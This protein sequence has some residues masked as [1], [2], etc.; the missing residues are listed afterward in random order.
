M[1]IG[2]KSF[3][4]IRQKSGERSEPYQENNEVELSE[5]TGADSYD[6]EE[7]CEQ[8]EIAGLLSS[9]NTAQAVGSTLQ[10]ALTE[11]QRDLP[12]TRGISPQRRL[13]RTQ[14]APPAN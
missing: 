4:P 14:G 1:L 2:Q 9:D 5:I 3:G 13:Y 8:H 7:A 10:L 6:A 12:G 11:Y